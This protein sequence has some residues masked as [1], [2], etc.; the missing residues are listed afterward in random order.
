MPSEGVGSDDSVDFVQCSQRNPCSSLCLVQRGSVG[1]F[2]LHPLTPLLFSAET[3]FAR[4][5]GEEDGTGWLIC[6]NK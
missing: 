2:S 4:R 1:T 3:M 6:I 5:E